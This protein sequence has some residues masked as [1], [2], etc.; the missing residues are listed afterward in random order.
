MKT[1]HTIDRVKRKALIFA[2]LGDAT[3][4]SLL[5]KLCGGMA[6]SITQL[7]EDSKL[8]RQAIT[9]HLQVL[10]NVGVVRGAMAGRERLF[11]LSPEPLIQAKDYLDHVSAQWDDALARL[12]AHV[13]RPA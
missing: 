13:E 1:S 5:V 7:A 4:L 3:R 12:K 9:K 11:K 8:T 2:A 10:Q 6:L